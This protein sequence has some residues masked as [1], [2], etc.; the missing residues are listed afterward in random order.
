MTSLVI[1]KLDVLSGLDRIEVCTSYRGAKAQSSTTSPTTRRC[2]TTSA[3]KLTELG[4]GARTSANAA[5]VGPPGGA[6]EYLDFIAERRRAVAL[7]GV[8]PG[9]DQVVWTDAGRDTLVG[10]GASLSA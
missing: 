10:A 6:R 4:A 7:I 3:P 5:R 9:R 2:C 8:G 1:T